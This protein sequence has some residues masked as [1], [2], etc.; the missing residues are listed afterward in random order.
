[1]DALN[2]LLINAGLAVLWL[3]EA[4]KACFGAAWSV[5][6]AALNPILSPLF[7]LLNPPCTALGDA[8]FA[9]LGPL[10]VWTGLSIISAVAGVVMLAAFGYTSNQTAIGRAKDDIKA[11]LLALKLYKDQLHV[12]WTA[13]GR[14]LWAILR[15]Q[16]YMLIPVLVLALP[17]LLGLAQMGVRYQWRPLRVGEVT[18]IKL[19]LDDDRTN[20]VAPY[21]LRSTTTDNRQSTIDNRQSTHVTLDPNPGIVVE[22]GP[23]P[24]EREFAWRIRGDRPGRHTLTFRISVGPTGDSPDARPTFQPVADTVVE[25]ELVVGDTFERVS[26][27]RPGVHWTAQLFHPVERSLPADSPVEFIEIL[28]PG[29]GS[30]I[31]GAN[32]WVL[33]FFVISMVFALV[34]KP[35]FKVRF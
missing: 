27:E 33:F 23:V 24:A 28:Y 3:W 2:W 9:I 15:L 17:M 32:Y 11:N 20:T 8:V 12:T 34:F 25:K 16:R 7:S 19:K 4:A 5:L 30:W 1:M 26:A 13:Q 21:A 31:Y 6:D 22:V 29:R 14:L 35:V 18:L 10:P